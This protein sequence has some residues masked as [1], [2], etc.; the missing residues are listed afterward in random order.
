MDQGSRSV[1]SPDIT[2]RGDLVGETDLYV[3]GAVEGNIRGRSLTVGPSGRVVGEVD[4]RKVEVSGTFEGQIRAAEI[5]LTRSAK[6]QGDIAAS[7]SLT[8]ETG[9]EFEGHCSRTTA[10]AAAAKPADTGKKK[11]GGDDKGD[12]F[13]EIRQQLDDQAPQKRAISA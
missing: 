10:G 12:D 11:A 1:I 7:E 6:V 9:A 4:A 13:S 3:D 8:V 5:V 2:V